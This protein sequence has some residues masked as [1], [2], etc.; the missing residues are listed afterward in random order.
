[1]A[2]VLQVHQLTYSALSEIS[3]QLL[4]ST[5]WRVQHYM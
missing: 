2:V 1:M 3:M 5:S 4:L